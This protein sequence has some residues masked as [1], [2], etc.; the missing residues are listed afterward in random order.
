MSSSYFKNNHYTCFNTT[1]RCSEIYYVYYTSWHNSEEI[2]AY[3]ITL[4]LG[5]T[6]EDAVDEMLNGSD[7]NDN[8]SIIKGIIENWY[9]NNIFQALDSNGYSFHD[10]IEDTIYCN[11]RSYYDYSESGWN[12]NGGNKQLHFGSYGRK[13]NPS[14]ACPRNID[15][16]SVSSTIGN[17]AL[18]YPVGLLT[19]DELIL[20]GGSGNDSANRKYYL[21]NGTPGTT[22]SSTAE[23][24]WTLSPSFVPMNFCIYYLDYRGYIYDGSAYE[25]NGVRPVISLKP[26]TRT[27]GG[28]GTRD[29][30]YTIENIP[31]S[32]LPG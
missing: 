5:K 23:S 28:D 20:A 21:W 29:D 14:V 18:D 30:P 27:D 9:Y 16:F 17:G 1:G 11:D 10:Y 22:T 8:S 13:S 3:Y 2:I 31:D 4:P 32:E 19:S 26:G 12:S 7:V 6:V 24:W 25:N 15:K